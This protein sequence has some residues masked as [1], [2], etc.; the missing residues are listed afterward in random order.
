MELFLGMDNET[1]ESL[2]V[3]ISRHTNMGDIVVGVCNGLP[4]HK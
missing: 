3:E 4:H 1:T 2:W